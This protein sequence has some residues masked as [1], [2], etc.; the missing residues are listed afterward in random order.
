MFVHDFAAKEIACSATQ[1]KILQDA[2]TVA[3]LRHLHAAT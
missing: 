1:E 2:G 3:I